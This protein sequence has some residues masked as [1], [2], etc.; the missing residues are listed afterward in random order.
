MSNIGLAIKRQAPM[1]GTI[2]P[3]ARFDK[4]RQQYLRADRVTAEIVPIHIADDNS[5]AL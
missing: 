5:P 2:W 3:G 1:R 4:I